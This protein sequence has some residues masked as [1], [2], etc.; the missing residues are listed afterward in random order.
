MSGKFIFANYVLRIYRHKKD[1]PRG[2]VGVL[3]DA[4]G[5]RKKVFTNLGELWEIL[6]S[7]SPLSPTFPPP[8]SR[9]K[10]PKTKERPGRKNACGKIQRGTK[11]GDKEKIVEE[12][13]EGKGAE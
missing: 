7:V 4:G 1:N 3:E 10:S 8:S 5:K 13:R 6:N 11:G 12:V 2:L 9:S